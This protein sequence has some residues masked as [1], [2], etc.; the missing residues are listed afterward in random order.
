MPLLRNTNA[1]MTDTGTSNG[2]PRTTSAGNAGL[3]K[4]TPAARLNPNS[5]LA[6]SAS[7]NVRDKWLQNLR[8]RGLQT[9]DTATNTDTDTNSGGSGGGNSGGYRSSRSSRSYSSGGSGGTAVVADP[10][11]NAN[12]LAALAAALQA[13]KQARL[14]AINAANSALDQQ[15]EAMRGRYANSLLA[16]GNDYQQLR[17]QAE[18]NRYRAM[19][20]QREALANRGALDSG[21]GRQETLAMNTG[22]NNNLNRINLQEAAERASV[23]NAIDQMYANVAQQKATNM[24][25][26]LNDYNSALQNLI[27]AEYSGYTPESSTY[28]QQALAA[29][30]ATTPTAQAT[31]TPA[32][33]Q[34]VNDNAY[35]RYLRAMGYNV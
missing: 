30:G 1:T 33:Q 34:N 31:A 11:A 21:A 24:S 2:K 35:L 5:P 3:R 14:D 27:N 13:Q 28:Y 29:L 16:L 20:N 4:A 6:S 25:E 12:N 26:G 10:Q 15:A 18:A 9:A 7:S 8:A 22:Y 17:N 23:Q 32:R 19:Y